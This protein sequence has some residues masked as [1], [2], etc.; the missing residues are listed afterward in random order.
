MMSLTSSWMAKRKTSVLRGGVRR[1]KGSAVTECVYRERKGKSV[2]TERGRGRVCIQREEGE[3]ETA[4][5]H[6]TKNGTR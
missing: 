5:T 6:E 3:E 1:E 4:C 2:H